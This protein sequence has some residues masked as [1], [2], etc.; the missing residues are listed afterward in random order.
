MFF[1]AVIKNVRL[2]GPFGLPF[3]RRGQIILETTTINSFSSNLKS[4]IKLLGI[5]GFFREY[6]LAIFPFLEQ[7]GH[8][9]KWGRT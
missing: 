7:K 5:I 8:S 6:F 9:L 4:T 2:I 1:C 3:T